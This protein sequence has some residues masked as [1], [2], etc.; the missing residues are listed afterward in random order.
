M[1]SIFLTLGWSTTPAL[2]TVVRHGLNKDDELILLVPNLKDKQ[3]DIAIRDLRNLALKIQ[4]IKVQ[5]VTVPVDDFTEA[6]AA[7][8]KELDSRHGR[9]C[10]VNL[11]GG[12]RVLV[13]AA[14]LACILTS[15]KVTAEIETENRDFVIDLP[16]LKVRTFE[17]LPAKAV[18]ILQKSLID[19]DAIKLRNLLQFPPS[20]FHDYVV[21][22]ERSGLIT[23]QR[24]GKSYRIRP[25]NLGRLI[26]KTVYNA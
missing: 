6:T 8:K 11:S 14:Y 15:A 9:P 12:M 5:E 16:I 22:L 13:L 20:T 2:S 3:A 26:A 23:R 19:N 18:K 21:I 24:E 1:K 25:T 7:I 4:D 17:S 10:I